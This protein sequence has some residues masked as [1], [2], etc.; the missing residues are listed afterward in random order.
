MIKTNNIEI[1]AFQYLIKIK[2][3]QIA[4]KNKLADDCSEGKVYCFFDYNQ[5]ALII[6]GK[7]PDRSLN[8]FYGFLIKFKNQ[9]DIYD[10]YYQQLLWLQNNIMKSLYDNDEE[11]DNEISLFECSMLS[12]MDYYVINSINNIDQNI[13][14]FIH[15][16]RRYFSNYFKSK[17]YQPKLIMDYISLFKKNDLIKLASVLIEGN[18]L[19]V[20]NIFNQYL[21]KTMNDIRSEIDKKNVV[22][23][24][25]ILYLLRLYRFIFKKI[26][27]DEQAQLMILAEMKDTLISTLNFDLNYFSFFMT[28]DTPKKRNFLNNIAFLESGESNLYTKYKNYLN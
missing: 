10:L 21:N 1:P 23:L 25:D 24:N 11:G 13:Q 8:I 15:R 3:K 26:D 17:E 12:I 5:N 2:N 7:C 20:L 6:S 14:I 16:F 27:H 9:E 22:N 28:L 4:V 18:E 19:A